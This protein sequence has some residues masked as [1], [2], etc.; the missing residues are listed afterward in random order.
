MDALPRELKGLCGGIHSIPNNSWISLSFQRNG[1]W[2]Y[3]ACQQ[4]PKS[5][6]FTKDAGLTLRDWCNDWEIFQ[7]VKLKKDTLSFKNTG[8]GYISPVSENDMRWTFREKAQRWEHFHADV[9]GT[10]FNGT[11]ESEIRLWVT[12]DD[13][14]DKRYLVSNGKDINST[15]DESKATRW[16]ISLRRIPTINLREYFPSSSLAQTAT[17]LE[18]INA[19]A[20][21]ESKHARL[22]VFVRV[23]LRSLQEIGAFRVVG[24]GIPGDLFETLVNSFGNSKSYD[25]DTERKD[26][27][28]KSNHLL[29][30]LRF[31]EMKV[32]SEIMALP[33]FQLD[34]AQLHHMARRYFQAMLDLSE[35]LLHAMALAQDVGIGS[36][37][38]KRYP[39]WRGAWKDRHRYCGL[40]A[41]LYQPGPTKKSDGTPVT[42]AAWH[43]DA[44]WLTILKTDSAG[45]LEL[46]LPALGEHR[47]PPSQG[48]LINVGNVM[49]R[50]TRR[51]KPSHQGT[52]RGTDPSFFKAVCHRVVRTSKA[53]QNTRISMP[54]FYDR[55]PKG[56]FY[57]GGTRG[58]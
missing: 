50:A 13:N 40:R 2:R 33:G 17:I 45:G 28:M 37:E 39:N 36:E 47:V 48:L 27:Q 49:T 35:C 34:R 1:K 20:L 29:A 26:E 4:N 52:S 24:H 58:C 54:F 18:N 11:C 30:D 19:K 21:E 8:G 9:V 23:V 42:T 38:R 3:V 46:K 32:A 7:L 51:V 41:L 14:S 15:L 57:G 22:R 56:E 43:T 31:G 25:S 10:K 16:R 12:L 5:R 55:N 44:T 6:N 53:T